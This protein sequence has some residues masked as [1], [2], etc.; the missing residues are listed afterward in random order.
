M[1]ERTGRAGYL[2]IA[3][4]LRER[5][6]TGE[7]APG[8]PL[9]STA[10]LAETYEVSLGVVKMA[11]GILRTE[12]LVVGQQ[13]KGVFVREDAA[14][15]PSGTSEDPL[16]EIRAA[17]REQSRRIER[18]EATVAELGGRSASAKK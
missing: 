9:P 6:R 4:D 11:V 2:Q 17:L 15:E 16:T 10:R 5:I 7:L 8:S 12:G 1:V 18:L 3:D 14:P 13:G